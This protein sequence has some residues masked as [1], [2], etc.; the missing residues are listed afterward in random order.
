MFLDILLYHATQ[1]FS[2]VKHGADSLQAVLQVVHHL[3]ALLAS[4][5]LDTTD[6]GCN[7]ALGD[8]LE[9]ADATCR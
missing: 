7:T 1:V 8:N 9:H 5:G 4:L 6:A 2:I 3:F